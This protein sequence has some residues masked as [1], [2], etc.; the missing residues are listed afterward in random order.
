M[1]SGNKKTKVNIWNVKMKKS[2]SWDTWFKNQEN[3]MKISYASQLS[4]M[5]CIPDQHSLRTA[6]YR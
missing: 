4:A 3:L 2:V 1:D 6:L 5:K